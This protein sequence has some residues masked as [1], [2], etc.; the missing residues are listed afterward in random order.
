VARG[1]SGGLWHAGDWMRP[2]M[3]QRISAGT[4]VGG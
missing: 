2:K 1:V 3:G 4:G